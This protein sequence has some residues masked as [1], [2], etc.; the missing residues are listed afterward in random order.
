M[1]SQAKATGAWSPPR[2][3]T[4]RDQFI[5]QHTY[6]SAGTYSISVTVVSHAWPEGTCPPPAGDPYSSTTTVHTTVTVQ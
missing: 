1:P 4:G 3:R 6:G 2:A 5:V